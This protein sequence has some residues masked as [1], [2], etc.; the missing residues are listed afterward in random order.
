MYSFIYFMYNVKRKL[1]VLIVYH[2]I[3]SNNKFSISNLT[4][5]MLIGCPV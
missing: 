5:K 2:Q 3:Q 1:S 4:L